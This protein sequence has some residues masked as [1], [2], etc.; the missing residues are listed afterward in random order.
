MCY[1]LVVLISDLHNI[2]MIIIVLCVSIGATAMCGYNFG[3]FL[4]SL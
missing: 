3:V 4:L 2:I 1:I